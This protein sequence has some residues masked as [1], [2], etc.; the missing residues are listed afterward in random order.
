VDSAPT[1]PAMEDAAV[2]AALT[3]EDMTEGAA[4]EAAVEPPGAA[5][6]AMSFC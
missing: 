5:A 4:A 6:A 1:A 3:T 2:F